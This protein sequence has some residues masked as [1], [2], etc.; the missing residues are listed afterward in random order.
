MSLGMDA[1]V[2]E[3][4]G[5]DT[6]ADSRLVLQLGMLFALIYVAFLC[7][8]LSTTRR[9]Q[10]VGHTLHR[11]RASCAALV[12]SAVAFARSV[13]ERAANT[14]A[15][16]NSPWIC[17]IAWKQGPVRSRFQAVMVTPDDRKRWV[18]AESDGLRWPPKDVRN[19]PTRELEATLGALITSIVD[20]GWE[21]VQ[22][23]GSWS[24]RRFVWRLTGEPPTRVR[25]SRRRP[26][27]S[28]AGA[29]RSRGVVGPRPAKPIRWRATACR[30]EGA[31]SNQRQGGRLRAS[32]PLRSVPATAA[33]PRLVRH[34][35]R[36]FIPEPRYRLT[37]RTTL[38]LVALALGLA[39]A[40]GMSGDG[41]S[42]AAKPTAESRPG[43]GLVT[44]APGSEADV[45]LTAPRTIAA[46]R[47]RQLPRG[48][49]AR[50]R[51]PGGVVSP[52]VTATP[53]PDQAPVM[54]VSPTPTATP[55]YAAPEP[56]RAAPTPA[57]EPKPKREPKPKPTPT[58]PT[59]GE[60]DTIGE[61]RADRGG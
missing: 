35:V 53:A 49:R 6:A 23:P 37:F 18:V 61:P 3:G 33:G 43:P 29:L 57:P 21:P 40:I 13:T 30:V 16:A 47:D 24:E 4:A 56:P 17:E 12:E 26:S 42:T 2:A 46:L 38:V 59:S 22:S 44:S 20:T 52:S 1:A 10:D 48:R 58:S 45:K 60:F 15:T 39:F 32:P 31:A 14:P 28:P 25:P 9:R 54:P 5:P 55:L 8:W 36:R 7:F 27:P 11:V 34:D 51:K 50:A 41:G 19:P